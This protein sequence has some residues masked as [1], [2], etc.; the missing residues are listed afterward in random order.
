MSEMFGQF[1]VGR[2]V[3][4]YQQTGNRQ[5]KPT[6]EIGTTPVLPWSG[7]LRRVVDEVD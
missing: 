6:A 2:L 5:T 3:V 1:L 4:D 7:K